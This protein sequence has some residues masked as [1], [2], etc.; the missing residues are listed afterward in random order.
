[1]PRCERDGAKRSAAFHGRSPARSRRGVEPA[2]ACPY[3]E[4]MRDLTYYILEGGPDT[5]QQHD[6]QQT[7]QQQQQQ[8]AAMRTQSPAVSSIYLSHALPAHR[9][10]VSPPVG[11]AAQHA[12]RRVADDNLRA[13]E[14]SASPGADRRGDDR[15]AETRQLIQNLRLPPLQQ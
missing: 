6:A 1:M 5:T 7:Q 13:A 10:A 8:Q 9:A 14:A 4:C 12:T 2:P 3:R 15:V 11:T